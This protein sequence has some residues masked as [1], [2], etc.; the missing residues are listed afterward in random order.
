VENSAIYDLLFAGLGVQLS[1]GKIRLDLFSSKEKTFL[2]ICDQ[3]EPRKQCLRF[4][5]KICRQKQGWAVQTILDRRRKC[6]T[7]RQNCHREEDLVG[8][9][10]EKIKI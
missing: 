9:E 6:Q 4:Q 1:H 3:F 2:E 8:C 7:F 10:R 5:R